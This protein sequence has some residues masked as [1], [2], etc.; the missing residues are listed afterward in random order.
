[1]FK[2][3]ISASNPNLWASN[4]SIMVSNLVY[5]SVKASMAADSAEAAKVNSASNFSLKLF[6]K[7][8][9][10]FNNPSSA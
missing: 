9:T 10:L 6:N 5:S 7:V 2:A 8:L 3:S 1:M 4:Y